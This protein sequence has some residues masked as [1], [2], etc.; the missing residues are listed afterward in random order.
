MPYFYGEQMHYNPQLEIKKK[1]IKFYSLILLIFI[2]LVISLIWQQTKNIKIVCT[3]V[4]A[5]PTDTH[6]NISGIYGLPNRSLIS[7]CTFRNSFG[8]D[9]AFESGSQILKCNKSKTY[10]CSFRKWKSLFTLFE[11]YSYWGER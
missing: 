7:S 8:S 4:S 5:L 3:T 10:F 9:F 6:F 11:N 2:V 1:L